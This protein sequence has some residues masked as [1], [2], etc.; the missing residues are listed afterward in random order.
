M[1]LRRSDEG[2]SDV[3]GTI[4]LIAITVSLVGV[5][6]GG[7]YSAGTGQKTAL[8][9]LDLKA[10]A[11][12][13]GAAN[14]SVT[15]THAGGANFSRADLDVQVT[16]GGVLYGRAPFP[17][18]TS[19]WDV[20]EAVPFNLSKPLT[21]GEHLE[22]DV[23][24]RPLGA[25]VS[26]AIV[27]VPS[28]G[29]SAPPL[30]TFTVTATAPSGLFPADVSPG[31]VLRV[32]AH[33]AHPDG[34]KAIA[35]AWVDL[36]PLH[37]P[38]VLRLEDDGAG[39]DLVAGDMEFAAYV[40]IPPEATPSDT[41]VP[42][43]LNALDVDGNRAPASPGSSLSVRVVLAGLANTTI[44][45]QGNVTV[46][47]PTN[48]T[49]IPGGAGTPGAP[50]SPGSPGSPGAP[51]SGGAGNV[52]IEGNVSNLT[53]VYNNSTEVNGTGGPAGPPELR[54]PSPFAPVSGTANTLVDVFGRNFSFVNS[55]RL[56]G[57]P[58]APLG[59]V[60]W[61]IDDTHLQLIAPVTAVAGD[62]QVAVT[63]PIGSDTSV[64]SFHLDLPVNQP[65]SPPTI[66]S[67][68][69]AHGFAGTEV[70][71][72]GTNL[73]FL[74]SVRLSGGSFVFPTAFFTVGSGGTE[75]HFFVPDGAPPT[76]YTVTASSAGGSAT[77][78]GLFT[79]DPPPPTNKLSITGFTP[80]QGVPF[81]QINLTGTGF[82]GV[83][84]ANVGGAN[85]AMWVVNDTAMSVLTHPAV[86]VQ[87]FNHITLFNAT[88]SVDVCCF[89]EL[90]NPNAHEYAVYPT[91]YFDRMAINVTKSGSTVSAT[92]KFNLTNYSFVAGGSTYTLTSVTMESPAFKPGTQITDTVDAISGTV[93]A[94]RVSPTPCGPSGPQRNGTYVITFSQSPKKYDGSID[95]YPFLFIFEWTS[96]TNNFDV[97]V[98]SSV[99][100][101]YFS[102]GPQSTSKIIMDGPNYDWPTTF[103]N[104]S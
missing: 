86:P 17:N 1:S 10:S 35:S 61:I 54:E 64:E 89:N 53:I 76:S 40:S 65:G 63:D 9:R 101:Q 31:S 70:T 97:T 91:G 103:N 66:T 11:L 8:P 39:A 56:V 82:L 19:W 77:A 68:T 32:A 73:A 30:G 60:W 7:L 58:G 104:C 93:P 78:P 57:G 50:G 18:A 79:I 96:A 44:N 20:G 72:R 21:G 81:T 48:V 100:A 12:A 95:T 27:D 4:I 41:P 5:A 6:V 55:V 45:N 59:V 22:I 25:V 52:T 99:N 33:V 36:S 62:Y 38:A 26:T 47:N 34:R 16:S 2:V 29:S 75:T 37:G 67:M 24:S 49:I 83:V 71:L 51:G 15:L 98:G 74:S 28:L 42:L 14:G 102:L 88:G 90:E 80:T 94:S 46:N 92:L 23:I 69:P 87:R 3:I 13:S 85:V 84:A 43:A